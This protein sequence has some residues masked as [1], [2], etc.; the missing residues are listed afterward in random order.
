LGQLILNP[1]ETFCQPAAIIALKVRGIP[2]GWYGHI[3]QQQTLS[4]HCRVG[5]VIKPQPYLLTGKIGQVDFFLSPTIGGAVVSAAIA[6]S[7]RILCCTGRGG[8]DLPGL[9]IRRGVQVQVIIVIFQ[10][11][12]GPVGKGNWTGN[13]G[14]IKLPGQAHIGFIALI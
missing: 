9:T 1:Y 13:V 14:K 12:P 11:I 5:H 4:I 7:G 2:D 10:V 6:V 8:N 3:I